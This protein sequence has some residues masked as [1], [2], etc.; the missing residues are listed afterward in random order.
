MAFHVGEALVGEGNEIAHIDL[1]IGDKDGPVGVAFANAL[2]NQSRGHSNLLAVLEPNLAVKP[3]TVLITKVTIQGAKQAVQMFGPAQYAVAK[4]VADS[5]AAGVIPKDQ[6]ERLVIVCGVFI[7][8]EAEDN[9]K[10]YQYNYDATKQALASAMK[11]SPSA[12]DMLAK[13]DTAKHPFAGI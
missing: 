13:K 5:V 10:I 6:C 1:I 4:A 2:A 3:S 11:D 9:S 8:W 7:H 12:N